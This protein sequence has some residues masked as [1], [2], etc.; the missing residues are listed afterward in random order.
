M[1]KNDFKV[2]K[3]ASR[4]NVQT[5]RASEPTAVPTRTPVKAVIFDMDGVLLDTE[6]IC[7]ICW[8]R[9]A[10]E[11][12]I[13]GISCVYKKC[14][15]TNVSDTL[16]IL[17]NAYGSDFNAEKFYARTSELFHVVE[18][19]KGIEKMPYAAE[20]LQSLKR[21][22][23]RLAL[24]SSTREVTVRR[25]LKEAGLLDFFET[26]TCGDSVKHSKPEPDI[27]IK[28]CQSLNL[29][30]EDCVAVEDSFN[31]V[32]SAVRAGMKCVMIPDQLEPTEEIKKLAS[33]VLHDLSELVSWLA[34]VGYH[35]S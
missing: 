25:Q 17:K 35:T 3:E 11:L 9:A 31:G 28:A 21:A 13:D 12:G 10:R 18:A 20:C 6:S 14:V 24:A 22:G 8:E 30:P 7:F 29:L 5:V 32:R 4:A 1:E 27:Y 23:Y 19:E 15:G 2:A 26:V 33:T 34:Q 16:Q